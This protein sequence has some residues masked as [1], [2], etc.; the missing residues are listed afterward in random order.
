MFKH[1]GAKAINL[2]QVQGDASGVLAAMEKE[3]CTAWVVS[4]LPFDPLRAASEEE[5]LAAFKAVEE[6][7]IYVVGDKVRDL[8][9]PAQVAKRGR[10]N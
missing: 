6:L 2:L 4:P 5:K 7:A 8:I 3:K 1:Q 10:A 9:K